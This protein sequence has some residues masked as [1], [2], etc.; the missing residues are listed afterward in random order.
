MLREAYVAEFSHR[1]ARLLAGIT[2]I[3]IGVKFLVLPQT[4]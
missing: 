2:P 3:A 1:S 4:P